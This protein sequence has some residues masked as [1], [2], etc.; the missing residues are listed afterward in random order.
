[1]DVLPTLASLAGIGYRNTTLGR[2]LLDPKFDATRVAFEFQFTGIGEEGV[3]AGNYMFI[4]RKPPAAF[5]ILSDKPT[6]NLLEKNPMAPELKRLAQK[7]SHFPT[8]Y[9]NAALYLQT[10]NPRFHD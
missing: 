9:G 5:D 4:N 3:L 1:M 7:W 2:D 8:A 10:H 6:S